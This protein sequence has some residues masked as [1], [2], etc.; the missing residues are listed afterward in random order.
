MIKKVLIFSVCISMSTWALAQTRSYALNDVVQM[1]R[2]KSPAWLSAETRKEN[3][4]WRYKTFRSNYNPQLI[5]SGMLPSY[6]QRVTPVTQPDGSIAYREVNNNTVEMQLGLS[7]VIAPTGGT[8]QI[9][10]NLNRFDDFQTSS[11]FTQYSGEPVSI[12]L[13]QPILQFNQLKWDKRIAPLEYEESQKQYFEELEQISVNATWRFFNLLLAQISLDIAQKNVESNDTIFKIAQGRYNLGK[14]TEND[15]LKLE[16]N[17]VNSRLA[18]TKAMVD[19]ESA[20]LQLKSFIGLSEDATVILDIPEEIP[21]FLVDENIA[22]TEARKNKSDV[23]GF[24]RQLLEAEQEVSRARKSSG[25]NMNLQ[26]VYGLNDLGS[27]IAEVYQEPGE[28]IRVGLQMN[29]P[30]LDWGR[31]KARIRRAEANRK[32][33]E[34]Q[35]LQDEETFDQDILTSARNFNML[36]EQVKSRVISDDIAQKAY[37]ISKQLFLIGKISITDL[38]QSIEAKDLAKQNYI[39]SLRDYWIAYFELRE[40]TLYDFHN[41][42]LLLRDIQT[43]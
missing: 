6:N 7:Q 5:L 26:A 35:I 29:V 28:N 23:V 3:N 39:S 33:V 41:N 11:T 20:S 36:K 42:Q 32:L 14:I 30:V 19:Q 1:A 25:V 38:N 43:D 24:R 17:L 15:L 22:L 10:S 37:E 34:Y 8:V 31:Q 12:G 40:K 21:D 13:N 16:L 4:Y 27:E 2:T 18:V 9:Y